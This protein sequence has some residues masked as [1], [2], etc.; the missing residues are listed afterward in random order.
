M[1]WQERT[2][3]QISPMPEL[4]LVFSKRD[5]ARYCH[6]ARSCRG[7]RDHSGRVAVEAIGIMQPVMFL[8]RPTACLKP[9][10]EAG[11][12]FVGLPMAYLWET[13]PCSDT[14]KPRWV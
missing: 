1:T 4:L 7:R 13:K 3:S 6:P 8:T 2:K 10:V 14:M 5:S 11:G 9:Q 12:G